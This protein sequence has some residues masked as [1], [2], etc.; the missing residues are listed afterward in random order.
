MTVNKYLKYFIIAGLLLSLFIPFIVTT[1]SFFPF[2][3]GK[4]F[5]FRIIT[6]I[7]FGV[8]IIL[9]LCDSTYRPKFS[10]LAVS[11][12]MFVLVIGIAD[13]FSA[14]PYK[15][16]W[17][18]FERMEGYITI[19]H[20][21]A[22]F[23]VASC[24]LNTEKLWT[25][26]LQTSVGASIIMSVYGMLQL[27]GKL[28]INQG[29]V[30]LDGTLGNASYLAVYMML[31]LFI[32][33]FLLVRQRKIVLW[34]WVYGVAIVSQLYI[35]Y[36]T[37]TRGAILGSLGG[38]LIAGI[39]LTLFSHIKTHRRIGM[40]ALGVVVLLFALGATLKNTDFVKNQ[41]SLVRLTDIST[42]EAKSRFLV[43]GMAWE[44]F[45][46]S[47]KTMVIG[48]GQESFNYVFNKYYNPAMYAQEQWFDRTHDIFFDWLVAGGALGLL[49][50]L[51]I[52]FFAL[53][54]IWKQ[55]ELD[56][57][58]KHWFRRWVQFSKGQEIPHL[59][60][61]VVLTGLLFA[62]VFQNIF[63]F[64]NITSYLLFFALLAY[65][66][67]ISGQPIKKLSKDH[68]QIEQRT[69]NSMLVPLVV[70]ATIFVVYIANVTPIRASTSLI[71][72]LRP[73]QAGPATN[74]DYFKK[75]LA[76]NSLGN[77][78]VREQLAQATIQVIS[79]QSVDLTLKQQFYDLTRSELLKQVDKTPNDARYYLFLGSFLN[80]VHNY[81]EALTALTK[82][83]E[84]S[85]KKQTIMFELG[86][87]YINKGDNAKALALMKAAFDLDQSFAEARI[88][89]AV[90]LVYAKDFAT[91]EELMQPLAGTAREYDDRLV[92][93]YSAT[94][95]LSTVVDLLGK[96]VEHNPKDSQARFSLA[97]AYLASG[98]RA[99]A[100]GVLR[101]VVKD[102]S[103]QKDKVD[104]ANYYIQEIQA[105][106]N[107]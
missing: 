85:P 104:Q 81:D 95:R 82:A 91:A 27:A 21:A 49:G 45:K 99:K 83:F 3:T 58:L 69:V 36:H 70:V 34:R 56:F 84:L 67:S 87:T 102:F 46:E 71:D 7:I 47:P 30:R 77:P 1:H 14:N 94:G 78:E 28:T 18:N 25:F 92:N 4:N 76:L 60:E 48:W 97:A 101:T 74:L 65:L 11:V 64:D 29:G 2:I 10:W 53:Y 54:Y 33:L 106:R 20:L 72:A 89:Y 51:S 96:R 32:V 40:V 55:G 98:A 38:V 24:V 16:F 35:L 9:A 50:Y 23:L 41:P 37:A 103:D 8:W 22:Y 43:W 75:T 79:G 63:V 5:A 59:L 62:Y 73:Q 13:I 17:S 66:H 68:F 105:G 57:S 19:L 90:A 42:S 6:E 107:P 100:V 31:N 93:A 44:G 15:S 26:F 86:S 61:K 39:L 12:G 52:L 88:I 80:R